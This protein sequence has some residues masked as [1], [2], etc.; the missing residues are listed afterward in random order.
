MPYTNG[1][2]TYHD[3]RRCRRLHNTGGRI[4]RI[5]ETGDRDG[6][7][8]CADEEAEPDTCET[9][10]SDGEVCG[11]DLPCPYHSED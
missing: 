2:G 3:R 6:C 8:H 10:M 9:V 7:D 5:D 1:S 11:R 4:R